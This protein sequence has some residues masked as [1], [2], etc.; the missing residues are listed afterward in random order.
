MF[1]PAQNA[2]AFEVKPN[3]KVNININDHREH[4]A[5]KWVYFK[6]VLKPLKWEDNRKAL[7]KLN[8]ILTK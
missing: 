3:I 5:Y 8:D 1:T 4:D 2:F 6:D 7:R